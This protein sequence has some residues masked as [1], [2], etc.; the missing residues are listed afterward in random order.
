VAWVRRVRTASG[1]TAVQIAESVGGRRRIVRHVGS[2]RDEAELGLLIAEANRLLAR[3]AQHELDLGLTPVAPKAVMIPAPTQRLFPG[4]REGR[5]WVRRAHVLKTSSGLLYEALAGVY[6]GLGFDA[7]GDE[8]FRDLVIARVVEP[9]SLLDVDRVLAELG[10]T[11]ASLSTRKRTLRR[12]YAGAYRD[13]LAAAC[14]THAATHGDVTLVLYDVTTL[15]FEADKE[16]DLRKVGYSKERRVDPQIVVGLLV[17]RQGFPLEVGCFEGNKAETLTIVPI[18]TAFQERHGIADMV[19]VADAG[20]LSASNLKALDEAGLRFIVGSRVTKAPNDLASHFRW[21]GDAFTDGQVIDTIT[22]RI[23]TRKV[24]L[25]N[26]EHQRAE[27]VWDPG[28]HAT[29][30][31][32]VWAYSSKR[33]VR[34]GKTLTLQENRA[35]AV[36]AGEKTTRTPR[37]VTINN[38]SRSL[39]EASLARARRLIGLKGYVTN[40]PASLMPAA[41]VIASYHDLWHVEQ[42]FRMSK[43]DLAARPIF[44][45]TREAIEAHLTLVFAALALSRTIQ[46][47]TG[48]SLRRF[49]R[50]LKPLRS[51]T[52][53][54]N[55]VINTYPPSIEP[56]I[57]AILTA[58]EQPPPRH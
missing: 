12:A 35:K 4:A 48:L 47:R 28:V 2:A 18:I 32:A 46:N 14:F 27:P 53:E 25:V 39:D 54:I 34:D 56:E 44:A 29:S 58:L 21:H 9:T 30:W 13:T 52:I 3:D 22:P 38:G 20:M 1:A 43:T 41:E 57:K 15:Y 7:V 6:A 11:S 23:A 49:L 16:D 36:V 5:R 51:A 8:V 37:F 55:G 50:T 26:D 19:I 24:A 40:I 45:R 10:R 31:R 33:A 17:D 42:S